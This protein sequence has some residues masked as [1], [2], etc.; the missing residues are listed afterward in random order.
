MS[1]TAD[2]SEVVPFI[3]SYSEQSN[4]LLSRFS[5][6]AEHLAWGQSQ[7]YGVLAGSQRQDQNPPSWVLIASKRGR[8][9]PQEFLTDGR[10]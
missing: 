2:F 7:N 8:K 9:S 5:R 6:K 10:A 1:S 4:Q 3:F